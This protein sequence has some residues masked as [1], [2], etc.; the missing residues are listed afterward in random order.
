MDLW[1][2][3]FGTLALMP[4]FI[5]TSYIPC[6]ECGKSAP[7]MRWKDL[8]KKGICNAELPGGGNCPVL[9]TQKYYNCSSESCGALMVKNKDIRFVPEEE[10]DHDNR[11]TIEELPQIQSPE[12]SSSSSAVRSEKLP[13]GTRLYHFI[14]V[15]PQK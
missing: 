14:D 5:S 8:P 2:I 15:K 3:V 4:A 10:C 13:G 12:V 9:R 6:T 1:K 11:H 7:E